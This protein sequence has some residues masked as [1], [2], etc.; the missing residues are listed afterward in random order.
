MRPAPS[1]RASPVYDSADSGSDDY[2][3]DDYTARRSP[4]PAR[5]RSPVDDSRSPSPVRSRSPTPPARA[6]PSAA[7]TTRALPARTPRAWRDRSPSM[8]PDRQRAW[9][10][11]SRR[12]APRTRARSPSPVRAP[13]PVTRLE[14][15]AAEMERN[16]NNLP[17]F[18]ELEYGQEVPLPDELLNEPYSFYDNGLRPEI[19]VRRA[20]FSY[21]IDEYSEVSLDASQMRH[22]K[23]NPTVATARLMST[24]AG[25]V[26]RIPEKRTSNYSV[27]NVYDTYGYDIARSF[28]KH[29]YYHKFNPDNLGWLSVYLEGSL[30]AIDPSFGDDREADVYYVFYLCYEIQR[31]LREMDE[32]QPKM[33]GDLQDIGSYLPSDILNRIIPSERVSKSIAGRVR[34]EK[35]DYTPTNEDLLAH[36]DDSNEGVSLLDASIYA[37]FA[38]RGLSME[39]LDNGLFHI[40]H[41]NWDAISEKMTNETVVY[42][43]QT[44]EAYYRSGGCNVNS[45]MQ[46]M[47]K[48]LLARLETNY[49]AHLDEILP[50][51]L[52][53]VRDSA[54]STLLGEW[55]LEEIW[56]ELRR[57]INAT[58]G[59][60]N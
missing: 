21:S 25:Y 3:L 30:K 20:P 55:T 36:H 14:I 54:P 52:L 57:L 13:R 19:T 15:Q 7:S 46:G 23:M 47:L 8:S 33:K 10:N 60:Y 1:Y 4:S 28:L 31:K 24:P 18:P 43:L 6:M 40:E 29:I 16:M 27:L 35:C 45:S 59:R 44:Y 11:I 53:L 39:S 37:S 32:S 51:F 17:D 49:E 2:D 34:Y 5:S 12:P 42:P 58:I 56:T 9:A 22:V 50:W 48:K 38:G 41:L 26:D